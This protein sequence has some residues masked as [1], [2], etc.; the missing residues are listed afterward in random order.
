MV[1]NESNSKYFALTNFFSR[2][3]CSYNAIIDLSQ[4]AHWHCQPALNVHTD[5]CVLRDGDYCI[6]QSVP[7]IYA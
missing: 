1:Q 7:N 2:A 5:L 4:R 3:L 6:D